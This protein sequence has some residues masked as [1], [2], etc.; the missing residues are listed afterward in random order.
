MKLMPLD[1]VDRKILEILKRDARLPFLKV[2]EEVGISE[3]AVRRRVKKLM[4]A[5]VL[6][7]FTIETFEEEA[8]AIMLISVDPAIPTFKV[9]SELKKIDG[10]KKVYEVTGESDIVALLSAKTMDELNACIDK[11]RSIE[12]TLKTNTLMVLR[13]W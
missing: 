10:V 6:K 2:A 11:A 7:R 9:S 13:S 3:G 5:K 4:E 8:S 1:D 12:G